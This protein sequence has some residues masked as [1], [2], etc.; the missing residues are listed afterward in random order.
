MG[1]VLSLGA[2]AGAAILR[3]NLDASVRGVQDMRALLSVPPL[4]AIPVIITQ[5]E[6][7]KHRRMMR[8]SWLSAF[9]SVTSM[10]IFVHVFVRPL[11]VV[12]I[13]LLH[14]FGM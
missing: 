4:A 9:V 6:S 8:Y 13:S 12:W 5:A 11:D 2:G 10:I 1:F 7:K 3:N 14:R